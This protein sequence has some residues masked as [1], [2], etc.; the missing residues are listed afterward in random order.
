M[1]VVL[2]CGG[3]GTRQRE[4]S[5]T[6]PKP[7]VNVGY[8]SMIWHLMRYC[9]RYGHNEF[10]LTL[11]YRGDRVRESF[12]NYNECMSNDFTLCKGGKEIA[13]H[14]SDVADW[15]ITFVDT[16]PHSNLGQRLLRVRKFVE[17]EEIFLA[18]YS[19]G[20]RDLALDACVSD[21]M[22][23]N[24]SASLQA[25]RPSQAFRDLRA[26]SKEMVTA[27]EPVAKS[28]TR[29]NGGYSCLRQAIFDYIH[30]G[31]E[32]VE[33]PFRRPIAARR[34][35]APKHRSLWA[36]MDTFK[37]R[38][39]FDRIEASGNC[40]RQV[41][42]ATRPR[43]HKNFGSIAHKVSHRPSSAAVVAN[44]TR[45]ACHRRRARFQ[46]GA[47]PCGGPRFEYEIPK[48][49]GDL[50]RPN[51]FVPLDSAV[52]Q[53]KVD[54]LMRCFPSQASKPRFCADSFRATM[55]LRGVECHARDGFA[56]AFIVRKLT[57]GL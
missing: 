31:E 41:W 17:V 54:V 32:L 39:Y 55:R 45:S 23:G 49:D 18:N 25:V 46:R 36:P 44:A 9:A 3:F 57:L 6:I 22:R 56:E 11:G 20:L 12:L 42:K 51:V 5:D 27:L 15:R 30:E 1:K 35:W 34:L 8:R 19:E 26:N 21:F 33:Q 16:G 28:D 38:I 2:F 48:Y 40:P 10:I 50:S 53:R 43:L 47:L 37:D 4:H 24:A 13:L 7:L 14:T 29:V 52:A